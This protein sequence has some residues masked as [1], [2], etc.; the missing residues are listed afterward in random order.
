MNKLSD[1]EIRSKWKEICSKHRSS[2]VIDSGTFAIELVRWAEHFF[3]AKDANL[4]RGRNIVVVEILGETIMQSELDDLS[5]TWVH[6]GMPR[7]KYEVH[8]KEIEQ[9]IADIRLV[10]SR[11]DKPLLP[12]GDGK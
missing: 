1:L 5:E 8:P 4:S 10:V 9:L 2:D 3:R 11:Y 7:G 6:F 12:P